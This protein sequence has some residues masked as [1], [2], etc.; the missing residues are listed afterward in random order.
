MSGNDFQKKELGLQHFTSF[1][2]VTHFLSLPFFTTQKRF[3]ITHIC[4][5]QSFS[6]FFSVF[7]WE[8]LSDFLKSKKKKFKKKTQILLI[9]VFDDLSSQMSFIRFVPRSLLDMDY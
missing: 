4:F 6:L 9:N 7:K 3:P 2:V 5:N 1:D 8:D